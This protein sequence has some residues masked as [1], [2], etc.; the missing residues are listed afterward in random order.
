MDDDK[1]SNKILGQLD[2]IKVTNREETG[3][4][5]Y[6]L[7]ELSCPL[8]ESPKEIMHEYNFNHPNF[9]HGGSFMC[10]ILNETTV[11]I[12]AVSFGGTEW[13]YSLNFH[14]KDF[15]EIC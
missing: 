12:E 11:E 9:E 4:G 2:K 3:V 15:S 1:I 8:G 14:E 5:F 6:T 10:S 7:I 13:P